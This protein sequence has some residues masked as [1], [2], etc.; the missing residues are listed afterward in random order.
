MES[1]SVITPNSS[2][3]VLL[4]QYNLALALIKDDNSPIEVKALE[5]EIIG[6]PNF[7]RT[8]RER[9][10]DMKADGDPKHGSI[11]TAYAEL[12]EESNRYH[13]EQENTRRMYA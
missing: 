5:H 12:I 1:I 6:D 3:E 4:A 2:I 10:N 9:L 8:I 11:L 13:T 7:L